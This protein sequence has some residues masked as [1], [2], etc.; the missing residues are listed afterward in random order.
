MN[1][2]GHNASCTCEVIES[3][4]QAN[5]AGD[6]TNAPAHDTTEVTVMPDNLTSEVSDRFVEEAKAQLEKA[7]GAL[8]SNAADLDVFAPIQ[9]AELAARIAWGDT[10]ASEWPEDY[11]PVCTC[12]PQLLERGGFKGDCPARGVAHA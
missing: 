5:R 7:L 11:V 3:G 12:P 10:P 9:L 1:S 6:A 8:E 4:Q 2:T